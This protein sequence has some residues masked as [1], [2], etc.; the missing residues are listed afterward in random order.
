MPISTIARPR[1]LVRAVA[2]RTMNV[3][4]SGVSDGLENDAAKN[5]NEVNTS[6]R[7]LFTF[8]CDFTDSSNIQSLLDL[9][10]RRNTKVPGLGE[11]NY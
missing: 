10:I 8:N 9:P 4:Q 5:G 3:E 11:I 6:V 2:L 1:L 7:T